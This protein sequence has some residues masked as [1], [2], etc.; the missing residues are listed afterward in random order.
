M[1]INEVVPQGS[2]EQLPRPPAST[3]VARLVE[4][5]VIAYAVAAPW[6]FI[7][8]PV[9]SP[10]QVGG[11]FLLCLWLVSLVVG[12]VGNRNHI[13][14]PTLL[15]LLPAWS[16][17][18]AFWSPFPGIALVGATTIVFLCLATYI[19]VC[20]I[21]LPGRQV[22]I[23]LGVSCTALAI[24][25]LIS[26]TPENEGSQLTFDDIDQNIL[27]F[28][29]CI[30]LAAAMWLAISSKERMK[31]ALWLA[32]GAII[33]L[34]I[35]RIGSRTGFSSLALMGALATAICW[36][37]RRWL[38]GVLLPLALLTIWAVLSA[39]GLIP[40]RI[41]GFLSEPQINDY[42]LQIID[43]FLLYRSDWEVFGVGAGTD[44]QFLASKEG[45]YANAHSAFW[46]VW[47]EL[48]IV[49]LFLAICLFTACIWLGRK[50][51][52]APF[53]LLVLVA[54]VLF[55]YTLGPIRSNALWV[56]IGLALAGGSVSN[57]ASPKPEGA[58]AHKP[59]ISNRAPGTGGALTEP[60]N[61]S[62]MPSVASD[63]GNLP[64][65]TRSR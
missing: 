27:S 52:L 4:Y 63:V 49:G 5:G 1:T 46:Q 12:R 37:S 13:V 2:R 41:Y 39:V 50:S 38:L 64:M 23:A 21:P 33:A 15:L 55:G 36:R 47:I 25:T 56:V 65:Q 44:A 14:V 51:Q 17:A 54:F 8:T 20:A 10:A 53:L 26:Q 24:R 42:R 60:A 28:T 43:Q 58:K 34:C 57:R 40:D 35:I 31:V 29:L 22:V 11:L 7:A 6:E 30:G 19:I 16:I 48:G 61:C 45:W 62:E 32:S 3:Q 18:T 59:S 9:G